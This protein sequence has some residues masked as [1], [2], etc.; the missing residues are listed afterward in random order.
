MNKLLKLITAFAGWDRITISQGNLHLAFGNCKL[1]TTSHLHTTT[2][3]KTT[4]S[5]VVG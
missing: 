2:T 5:M 1:I 3:M 4:A